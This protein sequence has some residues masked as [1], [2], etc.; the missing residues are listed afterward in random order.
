MGNTGDRGP[1]R[2]M[3]PTSADDMYTA[4]PIIKR[5]IR[6]KQI[7]PC[8]CTCAQGLGVAMQTTA[9]S[10]CCNICIHQYTPH[11]A[12]HF[13]AQH[14]PNAIMPQQEQ[15]LAGDVFITRLVS[16]H[17]R[18]GQGRRDLTLYCTCF[19]ARI[20]ELRHETARD[21]E[22][23]CCKLQRTACA[24]SVAYARYH[25]SPPWTEFKEIHVCD[26]EDAAHE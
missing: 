5:K 12:R 19:T 17:G 22:T 11:T 15:T 3:S 26:R 16:I 23:L 2:S 24:P 25:H 4:G 20:A 9:V 21:S 13:A 8:T 1:P 14:G 18:L 10:Y 7:L 6:Y